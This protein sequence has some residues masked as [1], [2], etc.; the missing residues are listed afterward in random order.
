MRGSFVSICMRQRSSLAAA[1]KVLGAVAC[2]VVLAIFAACGGK[3]SD[4]EQ[5][6]IAVSVSAP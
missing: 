4:V 5:T 6:R 1:G 3:S 2:I